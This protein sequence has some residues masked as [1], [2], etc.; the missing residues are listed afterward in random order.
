MPSSFSSPAPSPAA[1]RPPGV[2]PALAGLAFS[3]ASARSGTDLYSASVNW[4]F[5]HFRPSC[6]SHD[7]RS[8]K[9]T[10]RMPRGVG[11][12]VGDG[13][14]LGPAAALGFRDAD[15]LAQIRFILIAD[16]RRDRERLR[17]DALLGLAVELVSPLAS[18]FLSVNEPDTRKPNPGTL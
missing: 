2:L 3:R 6:S 15:Q 9:T 1:H 8:E 4:T 7:T 5:Q 16:L 18:C 10:C 12:G 17:L 14:D 11:R 13:V